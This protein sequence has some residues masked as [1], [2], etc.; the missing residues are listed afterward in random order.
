MIDSDDTISGDCRRRNFDH[1]IDMACKAVAVEQGMNLAA[2][3]QKVSAGEL[4]HI[5]HVDVDEID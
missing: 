3:H 2:P 1:S 4:C 5:G